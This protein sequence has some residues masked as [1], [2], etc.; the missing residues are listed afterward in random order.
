MGHVWAIAN[1]LITRGYLGFSMNWNIRARK[2]RMKN[3]E[4]RRAMG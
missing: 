2:I 4:L 3:S 1:C